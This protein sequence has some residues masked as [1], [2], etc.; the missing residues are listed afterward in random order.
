[1]S[2]HLNAYMCTDINMSVCSSEG[3][4]EHLRSIWICVTIL[5]VFAYACV[6]VYVDGVK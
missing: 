4:W 6:L 5:Y 2:M 1:M 3:T